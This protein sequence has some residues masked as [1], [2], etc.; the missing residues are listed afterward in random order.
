MD[1]S[2]FLKIY[3]PFIDLGLDQ[4]TGQNHIWNFD[5]LE[6]SP[7]DFGPHSHRPH[8]EDSFRTQCLYWNQLVDWMQEYA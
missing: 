5:Y 2:G 1:E 7:E 3:F 6:G 4:G 8:L